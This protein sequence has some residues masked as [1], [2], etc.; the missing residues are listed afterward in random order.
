VVGTG[1][2]THEIT[3]VLLENN[4][5]LRFFFFFFFLT[6]SLVTESQVWSEILPETLA[7]PSGR[8]DHCSCAIPGGRML[9]LG[10]FDGSEELAD[11]HV[12]SVTEDGSECQHLCL[13][14]PWIDKVRQAVQT[15]GSGEAESRASIL[16]PFTA[17]FEQPPS[18]MLKQ[19]AAERNP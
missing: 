3:L 16:F 11:L 1:D 19:L 7:G 10:G 4:R 17:E 8:S 12:L 13:C 18:F 5:S 14:A 15:A 2:C 6:P 9:V